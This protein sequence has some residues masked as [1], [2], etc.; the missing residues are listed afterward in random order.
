MAP[1]PAAPVPEYQ[2]MYKGMSASRI[3]EHLEAAQHIRVQKNI[4]KAR[5]AFK[6]LI[7]KDNCPVEF[8]H[9]DDSNAETLR[10]A[11]VHLDCTAMVLFRMFFRTLD[12]SR[13]WIFLFIDASPQARGLELFAATFD[14][15]FTTDHPWFKRRLFPQVHIG[16]NCYTLIG[17]TVAT[18]W[19]VF[20]QV[21][22][23]FVDMRDFCDHVTGITTDFGTE[24]G[25][26]YFRDILPAFCR[27]LK[28]PIP[29]GCCSQEYLFPR[30]LPTIGW[31]HVPQNKLANEL[32]WEGCCPTHLTF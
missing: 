8:L 16:R 29:R 5:K 9:D 28:I 22:P 11:R 6:P 10:K 17:K 24:H 7:I 30:A 3:M 18:L 25:I 4:K 21:G 27:H 19:L 20:L 31:M 32:S 26:A 12:L 13:L 15:F 14:I 23:N 1:L 2:Q